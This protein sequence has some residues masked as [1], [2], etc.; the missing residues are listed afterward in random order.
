MNKVYLIGFRLGLNKTAADNEVFL[1]MHK[2]NK[3]M[4][5]Y[6]R[7]WSWMRRSFPLKLNESD[8]GMMIYGE[9]S[10]KQGKHH[11]MQCNVIIK[12]KKLH[13]MTLKLLTPSK[14]FFKLK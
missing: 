2:C 12:V 1:H 8:D 13:L 7:V 6:I 10:M 14:F 5:S 4:L 3:N 9:N 11:R